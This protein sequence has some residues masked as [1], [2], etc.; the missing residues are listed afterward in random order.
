MAGSDDREGGRTLEVLA[1]LLLGLATIGSA[2]SAFQSTRWSSEER[3][4]TRIASDERIEAS[5]LFNLGTQRIV[6]DAIIAS[7][8]AQAVAE[9]RPG[10]QEFYKSA[11][12]RKQFLPILEQWAA[13]AAQDPAS[14]VNLLDSPGYLEQQMAESQ[15]AEAKS[16][17]ASVRGEEASRNA[18][19]YVRISLFMATALFFAGVT[20]TFRSGF[21]RAGLLTIATLVIAAG[22]A[23]LAELPVA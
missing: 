22:A 12:V 10:L 5:R 8:Y 14:A 2:W 11:L 6:Y 9:E 1:A 21:V 16:N 4:E 19:E 18:D 17:E 15:A 23:Q 20:G 7:Q 13:Q 3:D